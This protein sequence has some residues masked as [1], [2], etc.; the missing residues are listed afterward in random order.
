MKSVKRRILSW[1]LTV[2]MI[3]AILPMTALAAGDVA[4]VGD[5]T[6]ATLD[7][8]V[9]AAS[10]GDTIELLAD[11]TTNGL[12]LSKNITIA[13]APGYTKKPTVT[14]EQYGMRCGARV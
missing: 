9:K 13:A 8:A 4:K 6:Y 7:E 3:C 12:N 5:T 1:I 14:F 10:K 2:V 11:A